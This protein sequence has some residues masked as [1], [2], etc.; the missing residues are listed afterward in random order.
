M[1]PGDVYRA[2]FYINKKKL[3]YIKNGYVNSEEVAAAIEEASTAVDSGKK[4]KELSKHCEDNIESPF[5]SS[6]EDSRRRYE[7]YKSLASKKKKRD[8]SCS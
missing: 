4:R 8:C 5:G 6:L 7:E 2:K 1:R 3:D